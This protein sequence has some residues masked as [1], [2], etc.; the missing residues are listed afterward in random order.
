[1]YGQTYRR[2]DGRTENLPILQ[3][4]RPSLTMEKQTDG[5]TTDDGRWTTSDN[6]DGVDDDDDDDDDDD[7]RLRRLPGAVT[8]QRATVLL[9]S[10]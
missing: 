5:R 7:L 9:L 2:T 3:D 1:M 4:F 10:I 8:T 6:D